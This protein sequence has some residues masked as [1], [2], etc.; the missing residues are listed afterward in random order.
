[1]ALARSKVDR[2]TAVLCAPPF[3]VVYLVFADATGG[4]KTDD[5]DADDTF[6]PVVVDPSSSS[7]VM[8]PTT[9]ENLAQVLEAANN[10]LPLVSGNCVECLFVTTQC[11]CSPQLLE[12]GTGVGKSATVME[13]AR[14]RGAKCLRLNMSS[15]VTID[16]LFGKVSMESRNK[17]VFVK[18]QFT[19]AFEEGHWLLLDEVNLAPDAVLQAIEIALDSGILQL[20]DSSSA[21]NYDKVIRRHPDFREWCRF[22]SSGTL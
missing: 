22:C 9:E 13:A 17:F 21:Q 1:M 3:D 5:A 19:Q 18:R 6:V 7:M 10:P 14:R 8:T 15:R 2:A 4:G 11:C 16:D 12:G 20:T